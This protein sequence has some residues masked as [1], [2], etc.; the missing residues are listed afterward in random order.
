MAPYIQDLLERRPLRID[1]PDSPSLEIEQAP[2]ALDA[3]SPDPQSTGSTVWR[4][5]VR[6]AEVIA[7][8]AD[9]RRRVVLGRRILELGSGTGVA[10]LACAAL[11]AAAVLMT[12]LSV[13]LSERNLRR[14]NWVTTLNS[15]RVAVA[16]LRWGCPR[17]QLA[18]VLSEISADTI[19]GAD[20][21]YDQDRVDQLARTLVAAMAM[22]GRP[23]SIA[24]LG[25]YSHY[26]PI[27]YAALLARLYVLRST[28]THSGA[29]GAKLPAWR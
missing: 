26:E 17:W 2:P 12:D 11:G 4:G 6:L 14:N 8:D 24:V 3:A 25:C 10:G 16:V 15:C 29:L 18:G 19:I 1:F 9:L 23:D 28:K 27:A 22:M 21:V 13:G 5:G 20:L 7:S